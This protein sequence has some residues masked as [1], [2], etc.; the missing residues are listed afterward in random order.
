MGERGRERVRLR[1]CHVE[2]VW[3]TPRAASTNPTNQTLCSSPHVAKE[4]LVTNKS[5]GRDE[6]KIREEE[7]EGKREGREEGE[8]G[9]ERESKAVYRQR[10]L[11][12]MRLECWSVG[13]SIPC[14]HP[15]DERTITSTS[16]VTVTTGERERAGQ[17]HRRLCWCRCL[18]PYLSVGPLSVTNV[19]TSLE[20]TLHAPSVNAFVSFV[21]SAVQ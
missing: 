10:G 9:E 18:V 4:V 21:A 7:R 16:T 20:C 19:G 13:V 11:G 6:R 8:E 1:T 12:L 17:L 15:F 3:V 5:D 2:G 14:T